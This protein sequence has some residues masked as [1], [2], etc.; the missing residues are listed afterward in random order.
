MEEIRERFLALGEYAAAGAYE[1]TNRSLFYRKALGL[2][3]YYENCKLLEYRKKPLYPSGMIQ[4]EMKVFPN[5][6]QGLFLHAEGFAE[7]DQDLVAKYKEDFCAYSSSV[8]KEHVIAGDMWTHA[9]PNYERILQEGLSSYI[10]RIKKIKNADMREGLLHLVA[11]IERYA[12]R[13]VEYLQSVG[14]EKRLVE[15]LK[16]VPMYPAK[17][18]YQAIIGWN[19]IFYLDTCDNLGCLAKGL[20]PYYRGEDITDL[21][22]NLFDNVDLNNAWSMSLPG[23]DN[24]L[25]LQCLE[26]SKGKRRPMIE[27]LVDENTPETVWEKSFEV[28]KTMNGQPAFYNKKAYFEGLKKKFPLIPREDIERFCG[29]GCTETM[30]AGLSGVGSL[31]AGINLLLVLERTIYKRLLTAKNFEEFY[32]EYLK[33][34]SLVVDSVTMEI[35]RSQLSRAEK[36][37]LPM[38]T[39]L[40]DD[41]IDNGLDFN[42]GGARYKWS[43]IS[44][45][46]LINAIDSLLTI[47]EFVF[48]KKKYS[49]NELIEKLITDDEQSLIEMRSCVM[50]FGRGI[51]YADNFAK[52]FSEDVFSMLEN[53]KPAIGEAFLAASILFNTQAWGGTFVGATPDG[54]RAKSPLADSV[55]AILGKD[56]EGPIALLN[57]VTSLNLSGALGT[58]VLNFSVQPDY[59]F[60][61]FK[62]LVLGYIKSGG[63]QMQV[64]CVS[65]EILLDAYN[66]PEKYPNLVVRVAGYSERFINLSDELKKAVIARTIQQ[67]N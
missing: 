60:D 20:L 6:M 12:Q 18:I 8:P 11:G 4:N 34:V 35:S 61:V 10:Q 19:F 29:G 14:A 7:E 59:N 64:S 28:I 37:P 23:D 16:R 46:G 15:A 3:R 41:C 45:A 57:S 24:P 39:L 43:I 40:I 33:D 53:K 56:T 63:M 67:L 44:F 27:L 42:D 26:A 9:M 32:S 13:C 55:A 54:R 52:K 22:A 66:H 1:E 2:R 25:T 31:D 30:L 65:Q 47:R 5:Y 38:R 48:E 17:D 36:Q 21:I 50:A 58:P 49:P 51:E 62:G